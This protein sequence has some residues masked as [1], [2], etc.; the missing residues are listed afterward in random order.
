MSRV[1]HAMVSQRMVE[2]SVF[3]CAWL[4]SVFPVGTGTA[5]RQLPSYPLLRLW[6]PWNNTCQVSQKVSVGSTSYSKFNQLALR[7]D[8]H[9]LLPAPCSLPVASSGLFPWILIMTFPGC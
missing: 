8:A 9:G 6:A 7:C 3:V 1:I 4:S 2:S 5:S